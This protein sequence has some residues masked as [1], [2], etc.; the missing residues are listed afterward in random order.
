MVEPKGSFLLRLEK[1]EEEY[2]LNNFCYITVKLLLFA[3]TFEND[4]SCQLDFNPTKLK[5]PQKTKQ[6]PIR[7]PFYLEEFTGL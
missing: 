6:I 7:I 3:K 5:T 1:L 2:R 4:I